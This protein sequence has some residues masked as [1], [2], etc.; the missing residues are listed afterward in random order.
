ISSISDITLCEGDS[1]VQ[2]PFQETSSTTGSEIWS[3][4]VN[5]DS[6]G[7]STSGEGDYFPAFTAFAESLDDIARDTVVV[8]LNNNNPLKQCTDETSFTVNIYPEPTVNAISDITACEGEQVPAILFSGHPAGYVQ[9]DFVAQGTNIGFTPMALQQT[10][11]ATNGFTAFN[12][13]PVNSSSLTLTITPKIPEQNCQGVNETVIITVNP[14]PS[15]PTLTPNLGGTVCDGTTGEFLSVDNPLPG[16]SYLWGSTSQNVDII[17]GQDNDICVVAFDNNVSG[18]A[19]EIFVYGVPSSGC[20]S[21]TAIVEFSVTSSVAP[22]ADIAETPDGNG[23][24]YLNNSM[25]TYQWGLV[26][27]APGADYLQVTLD[28][29]GAGNDPF[30]YGS[31]LQDTVDK[32]IFVKACL[33]GCCA[34]SFYP[35]DCGENPVLEVLED[36]HDVLSLL[37]FPNPARDVLFVSSGMRQPGTITFNIADLTGQNVQSTSQFMTPASLMELDLKRLPPGAYILTV[38]SPEGIQTQKF[39]KIQ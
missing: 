2:I 12:T 35:F 31:L 5:G 1:G 9:F 8:T 17:A 37:L 25:D 23:L 32:R 11:N 3:W 28:E 36:A 14:G 26:N 39:L 22:C 18:E 30:Y 16:Y 6:T 27:L 10:G 21:D 13:S 38:K 19:I 4:D 20:S 29:S 7:V 33:E 34:T 24:V 15:A